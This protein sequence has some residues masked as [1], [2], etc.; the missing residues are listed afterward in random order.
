MDVLLIF[1]ILSQYMCIS[2]ISSKKFDLKNSRIFWKIAKILKNKLFFTCYFLFLKHK[3]SGT[4]NWLNRYGYR[5]RITQG[6]L[7]L[8]V[9][10]IF[11][12]F[13]Q[14]LIVLKLNF[15]ELVLLMHASWTTP[16]LCVLGCFNIKKIICAEIFMIKMSSTLTTSLSV[17]MILE[18]VDLAFFHSFIFIWHRAIFKRPAC[19]RITKYFYYIV[20]MNNQLIK[21]MSLVTMYNQCGFCKKQ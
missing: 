6:L 16:I 13:Q 3:V 19:N 15:S 18:H 11:M 12:I 8:R 1:E 14:I 2:K 5:Y 17:S 9:F 20:F 10:N 4:L 7:S 21:S